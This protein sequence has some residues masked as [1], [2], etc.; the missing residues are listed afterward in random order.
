MPRFFAPSPAERAALEAAMAEIPAVQQTLVAN[1]DQL[2]MP[3]RGAHQQQIAASRITLTVERELPDALRGLG[4][5]EPGAEHRGIGRISTGLGCP[6]AETDADFLGLMAAF[7]TSTGRR[8]DFITI[9]D[10]TSPTDTSAE[11]VALLKATADAA[12]ANGVLA[13]QATLLLSLARH[14]GTRAPRIAVHVT[15]QTQRTVRSRSAYQQYWT[16][17]VRTGATLAKF[18]FVPTA[19]VAPGHPP[20]RGSHYFRDEWTARQL[21]G[22]IDFDLVW[23]PFIDD[24]RTPLVD[25]TRVWDDAQQ[26]RVGRLRFPQTDATSRDSRLV[27]LLAQEMGAN[28]GHWVETNNGDAGDLPATAFTAARFLAYRNSQQTRGA[29]PESAYESFFSDGIV[30]PPLADEL[31]RRYNSKRQQQH[32]VPDLGTF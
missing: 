14:A 17:I 4:L 26:M 30:T 29:L 19:P 7:R 21:D 20:V 3:D 9:N 27:A 5:F 25:L 32:W 24:D 16:G 1:H 23:I 18:T 22:P 8:V 12:R 2:T 13:S 15:G 10:P 11:F 31:I 6:H 28:P